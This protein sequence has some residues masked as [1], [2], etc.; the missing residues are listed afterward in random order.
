MLDAHHA[1]HLAASAI[2]ATIIEAR[3]YASVGT[4]APLQEAGFAKSQQRSPGLLIPLWNVR[5]EQQGWQYRPDTP[6]V[7]KAGAVLKYENPYEMRMML[8]VHPAQRAKLDNPSEPLWITEGV[9][10]GDALASLDVCCVALMG[11]WN[12]RGRN[13]YDGLKTLA[14]W[15]FIALNGRQV[16]VVFDNDVSL[17]PQVAVALHRLA[18]MLMFRKATVHIV[19]LPQRPE[20][21]GVDDFLAEGHTL[22]ELLSLASYDLPPLPDETPLQVLLRL[23]QGADFLV[24]PEQDMYAVVARNAHQEVVPLAERG[25]GY[26]RWLI[27]RYVEEHSQHEPPPSEPLRRA[28]EAAMAEAEECGERAPV[29]VRIGGDRDMLSIDLGNEAWETVRI[30]REGYLVAPRAHVYFRRPAGM[31]PLPR[32]VSGGVRADLLPFLNVRPDSTDEWLVWGWLLGCFLPGG[33]YPHLCLYGPQGSAKSTATRI[34]RSLVDPNIVASRAVPKEQ[35][36]LLLAA[37]NGAVVALEN[38]STLPLWLSDFL[39]TLSTGGGLS[40]RKKYTDQDE[41]LLHGKRP[42]I[43]NGIVDLATRG[44][45]LDRCI[46]VNLAPIGEGERQA[47]R[48][49]WAAWELARPRIL[50]LLYEAVATAL[51]YSESIPVAGLPRMADFCA[52]VMAACPR[53]GIDP[54]AFL[55]AYKQNQ[56]E[57]LPIEIDASPVGA[58]LVTHCQE[59][60]PYGEVLMSTLYQE[61][62]IKVNS[63]GHL[64]DGW[65][66]DPTRFAGALRRIQTALIRQGWTIHTRR[67]KYGVLATITPGRSETEAP[68]F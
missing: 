38:L 22:A 46:V 12:W 48:G 8:D 24:S 39:C 67:G 4:S 64:P 9:K 62:S 42:A 11:V 55:L 35:E 28:M 56:D 17:K 18:G 54:A 6:R 23:A 57:S 68:P 58:A 3:G 7:T 61:L 45:L 32:P 40:R 31:L 50:G 65:P 44:D 51:K 5:G 26:R 25:S 14:D 33:P 37:Y 20:K 19:Y 63:G 47:E 43:L 13:S 2:A 60:W 1:Q 21:L 16:Y 66:K 59:G 34:L 15:D 27:R 29:W 10:K 53:L 52:W 30:W 49:F 36:D 41:S